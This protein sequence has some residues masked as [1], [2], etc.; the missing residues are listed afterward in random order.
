M[1]QSDALSWWPDH[2]TDEIDN[3]DIIVLPDNIF[4]KMIDLELQ[5]E[6]REETTKDDFCN[7]FAI[8]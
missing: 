1:I 3:D 8:P 7:G 2:I 6:I 4:I 5:N